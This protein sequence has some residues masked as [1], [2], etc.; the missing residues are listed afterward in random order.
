MMNWIYRTIWLTSVTLFAIAGCEQE[1]KQE[2]KVDVSAPKP[3][4]ISRALEATGGLQPWTKTQRLE[5]DCV[6]AFYQPDGS[7]YLTKQHHEIHPWSNLIR[8]SAQEPQ[9]K[10][11]WEF[12]PDG[13]SVIEGTGQGDFLPIGLGAEDFA[14]AIL[15][16]TTTPVRLLEGQAEL[17]KGTSPVKIEGRWYYPIERVR[18]DKPDSAPIRHKLVFYQNRNSY[19]VDMFWFA[20]IDRG[21]SLAV[22]GY[23]YHEIEK[24]SVSVPTKVEIFKTDAAGF[25]QQRLVKIDYHQFKSTK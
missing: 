5:F 11:I 14:K 10:F 25:F 24:G 7:Y 21:T 3:P 9:G 18:P 23:Y 2:Q 19:L 1:Q 6:V 17:I 22:R 12:S 15:D 20:G 13:M 4:Y 8:I 16:I